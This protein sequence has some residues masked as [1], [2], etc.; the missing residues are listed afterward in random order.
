VAPLQPPRRFHSPP[1]P[2]ARAP[3]TKRRVATITP[4]R[5]CVQMI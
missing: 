4:M 2:V 5:A 1:D 3:R